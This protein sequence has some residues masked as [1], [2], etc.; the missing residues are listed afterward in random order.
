[1][2]KELSRIEEIVK[3]NNAVVRSIIKGFK[4]ENPSVI[5]ARPKIENN[6]LNIYCSDCND[7]KSMTIVRITGTE[8]YSHV[9]ANG[10][11]VR[12]IREY[13]TNPVM[14]YC[15]RCNKYFFEEEKYIKAI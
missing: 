6:P 3:I 2:E 13:T 1:M 12:R 15:K 8:G 4:E 14:A 11:I 5:D 7:N 9:R 10:E